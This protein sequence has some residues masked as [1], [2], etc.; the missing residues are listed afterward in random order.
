MDLTRLLSEIPKIL[1]LPVFVWLITIACNSTNT[2]HH[3]R[4]GI[5]RLPRW[6]FRSGFLPHAQTG[7][8]TKE[9]CVPEKNQSDG[10]LSKFIFPSSS[11]STRFSFSQII[12]ALLSLSLSRLTTF[13]VRKKNH[14]RK[15]IPHQKPQYQHHNPL[16]AFPD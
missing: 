3:S 7:M 12:Q 15:A 10:R 14:R 9:A 16:S 11:V 4:C 5:Y 2:N 13:N 6:R 1:P 8:N